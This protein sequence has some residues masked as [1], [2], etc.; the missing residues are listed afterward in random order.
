MAFVGKWSRQAN[1]G[2]DSVIKYLE[3]AWTAKEILNLEANIHQVISQIKVYPEL[4]PKSDT[5]KNLHKL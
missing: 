5:Y 4:F 3:F 2:L 1:K